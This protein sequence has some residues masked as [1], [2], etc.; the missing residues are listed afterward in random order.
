MCEDVGE[1]WTFELR[2]PFN[3]NDDEYAD[4]KRSCHVN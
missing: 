4:A 2:L 1:E 3:R